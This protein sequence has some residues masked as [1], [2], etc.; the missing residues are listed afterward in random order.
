V[1]GVALFPIDR[2]EAAANATVAQPGA[3]PAAVESPTIVVPGGHDSAVWGVAASPDGRWLATASHDGTAKLWDAQ[4]LKLVRTFEQQEGIVWSVAF[5]PDSKYL[6]SGS[7]TAAIWEVETGREFLR[8][9]GHERLVVS[10]AFHP[11]QPILASSSLDGTVRLWDITGKQPLGVLHRFDS[12]VHRLAFRP[13]GRWLAA[14]CHDQCVAVWEFGDHASS[15]APRAPDHLLTGHTS[16]VWAVAFSADGRWL[17]SGADQGKVILWDGDHFG[18]VV[19]LETSTGQIRC[20]SFSRDG[21]LLAGAG[22]YSAGS[23]VNQIIVWDLEQVRGTL[24]EMNLD[25]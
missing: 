25:W 2:I 22:T 12:A 14:A 4:T 5:S 11:R 1:G 6:A 7:G 23:D 17:A 19:N 10:L 21:G 18:R 9:A 13:D 20:L 3:F 16:A 8:F 24:R 15:S